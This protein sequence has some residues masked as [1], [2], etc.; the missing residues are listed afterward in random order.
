MKREREEREERDMWNMNMR[1]KD[2]KGWCWHSKLP[3]SISEETVEE[4]EA[5]SALTDK[6]N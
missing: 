5:A 2:G 3:I 6:T 4:S 1:H